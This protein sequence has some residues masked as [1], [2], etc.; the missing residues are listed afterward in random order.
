MVQ[1]YLL[2]MIP[3]EGL[4][5]TANQTSLDCSLQRLMAHL[6]SNIFFSELLHMK[7]RVHHFISYSD[8]F[9]LIFY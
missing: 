4:P 5:A 3:L 8:Y 9:L 1:G 2:T 6:L 7:I